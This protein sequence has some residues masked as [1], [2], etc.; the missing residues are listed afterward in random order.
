MIP[1]GRQDITEEDIDAVVK[2]LR[3]DFV[4]QGPVIKN[5][6][7]AVASYCDGKHAV[8]TSSATSALHLACLALGVKTGD[9]VWTSPITFVASANCARYCGAEVSFVDIDPKTYNMSVTALENKLIEAEKKGE[10]PKVVIPVHLTGQSCEME[11]IY[12]L[13][14]KYGFKIIEDA[15]HAIGGR[16]QGKAIGCCSHSDISVFSFHPVKIITSGEGGMALTN[17]SNLAEKLL[18]LRNHGITR[19]S[20]QFVKE[21]DGPWVYEQIELGFNYRITDIQAALGLS[22]LNRLD[23][24]IVKRHELSAVYNL[25]FKD[26]PIT[27]PFQAS[28]TYSA[29]HLYIIRLHLNEIGRSKRDVFEALRADGVG[30]N[31]HYIPVHTQPYYEDLGFKNGGYPIAEEYARDAITLPLYPTMTEQEKVID[32]L[33]RVVS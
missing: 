8:A 29:Y 20:N 19:D 30:V 13:S 31:F 10:L 26:L 14:Q 2:V 18:R 6:E 1:Y 27:L 25:S 3:S 24:Y 28:D 21:P 33:K 9:W 7:N 23:G 11:P 5:F 17:D 16:Y 12:N 4:T 15:S 32:A 22:Q